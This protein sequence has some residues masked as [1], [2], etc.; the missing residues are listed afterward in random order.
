MA[1]HIIDDSPKGL[2][3]LLSSKHGSGDDMGPMDHSG[4]M[5]EG[6][7]DA[8]QDLLDAIKSGDAKAV[9]HAFQDCQSLC[10]D[11]SGEMEEKPEEAHE[12]EQG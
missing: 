11:D 8:A 1:K 5:P 2:A 3:V 4:E 9:A 6:L 12:A 10:D 7:E